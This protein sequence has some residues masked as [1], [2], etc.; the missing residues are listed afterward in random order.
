LLQIRSD[1]RKIKMAKL[2]VQEGWSV[3][4]LKRRV[5]GKSAEETPAPAPVTPGEIDPLSG[6]WSVVTPKVKMA[7]GFW[8]V[9]YKGERFWFFGVK[10]PGKKPVSTIAT[11]AESLAAQLRGQ[12]AQNFE[13]APKMADFH[14]KASA[15]LIN[16][17]EGGADDYD[18]MRRPKTP[19]DW[20][21]FEAAVDAGPYAFYVWLYGEGSELAKMS[22]GIT[23]GDLGITDPHKMA[24]ELVEE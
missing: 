16:Q 10:A 17:P 12:D 13:S 14:A 21:S 1:S 8:Q 7:E 2:T 11:W 4:E 6:V 15:A 23:W 19:E 24:R 5:E 3:R 9:T 20:K 18:K 22:K